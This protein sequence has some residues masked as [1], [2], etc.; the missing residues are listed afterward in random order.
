MVG[1]KF[2][3][4]GQTP[5][6][7]STA[8]PMSDLSYRPKQISFITWDCA[9]PNPSTQACDPTW[10]GHNNLGGSKELTLT[11]A[12]WNL[13]HGQ[14]SKKLTMTM[15]PWNLLMVNGQIDQIWPFDHGNFEILAMVMVK[16]DQFWPFD[17]GNFK[18]LAMVMVKNF[19]SFDHDTRT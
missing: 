13:T 19:W 8:A 14:W 11:M 16:N 2:F 5:P 10:Q 6:M 15:T 12:P 3:H 7:P 17:H 9:H 18:I 1:A 4:A